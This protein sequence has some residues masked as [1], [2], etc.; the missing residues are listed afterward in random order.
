MYNYAYFV[1]GAI[2]FLK[3]NYSAIRTHRE[4][5]ESGVFSR[6]KT[7]IGSDFAVL[8]NVLRFHIFSPFH[9][10]FSPTQPT[11][12]ECYDAEQGT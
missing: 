12:G 8:K 4:T 7:R 9:I 3:R 10:T 1:L 5:H 6:K 11:N 2:A